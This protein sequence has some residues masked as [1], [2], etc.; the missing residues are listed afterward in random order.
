MTTQ[1][2]ASPIQGLT[3]RRQLAQ[4][5]TRLAD[6][7]PATYL[8]EATNCEINSIGGITRRRGY[9]TLVSGRAHSLWGDGG[10][11]GYVVIGG[12]LQ[13]LRADGSLYPVTVVGSSKLSYSRGSDGRVYWSD[14]VRLMGLRGAVAGPAATPAPHA[15]TIYAGSGALVAG[16][17][18]VTFTRTSDVGESAATEPVFVDVGADGRIRIQG[19]APGAEVFV[20]G[21]NGDVFQS[22]GVC[23]T[24]QLD[25]AVLPQAGRRCET[26]GL[27]PMPAGQIVRHAL[28]RML[29]A[30]GSTLYFSEPYRYGL[31]NPVSGYL[32]FEAPITMVAPTPKGLYVAAD[33]TYWLPDLPATDVRTILPFGALPHSDV[34]LPGSSG[35]AQRCAWMSQRGAVIAEDMGNV[36]L[37]QDT[38]LVFSPAARGSLAVRERDGERWLVVARSGV[39]PNTVTARTLGD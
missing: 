22:V 29:V 36:S 23:V 24:G 19:C 17:Y 33:Q 12:V 9:N 39:E 16:R 14:E 32:P 34:V 30:R 11:F 26:I 27:K 13:Q 4:L 5:E 8:R 3:N 20:T 31:Y 28:G 10:D 21:P 25:V 35:E 38:A 7:T 2:I 6:G 1:K 37:P 18:G 15:P